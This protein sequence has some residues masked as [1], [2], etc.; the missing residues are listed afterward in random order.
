MKITKVR[1]SVKQDKVLAVIF[2]E[3]LGDKPIFLTDKQVTAAT[4]LKANFSI[5][6]GA[7]ISVEFFKKG[8]TL[9]NG[10]ECT[11]DDVIVKDFE[12]ELSD[13]LNN[14]AAA[15]SFGASMFG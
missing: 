14:I 10:K 11:E 1:T 3:E 5:L 7:D 4:G 15:A 9:L 12:L 2:T 6:K 13:R 8:D